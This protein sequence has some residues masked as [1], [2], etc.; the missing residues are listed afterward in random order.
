MFLQ[1]YNLSSCEKFT[2]SNEMFH[3]VFFMMESEKVDKSIFKAFITEN[4]QK[5]IN[6]MVET[7]SYFINFEETYIVER[8]SLAVS[9]Y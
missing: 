4:A 1:I 7:L 9:S 3:L 6:H 8:E 5:L 2:L